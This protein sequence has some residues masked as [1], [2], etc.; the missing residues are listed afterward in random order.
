MP[1]SAGAANVARA[2]AAPAPESLVSSVQFFGTTGTPVT[3]VAINVEIPGGCDRC[4]QLR[5]TSCD[6]PA[7]ARFAAR[8]KGSSMVR[9]AIDFFI[10]ALIAALFGFGGDCGRGSVDRQDSAGGVPGP[11]GGVD[12]CRAA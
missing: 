9:W 8:H 4:A 6:A 11:G 5:P 12:G 10:I 1:V 3:T 7:R 2:S